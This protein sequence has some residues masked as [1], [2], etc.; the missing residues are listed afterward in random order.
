[1]ANNEDKYCFIQSIKNDFKRV[2]EYSQDNCHVSDDY[3]DTVLKVW[4]RNKSHLIDLMG[5]K[6]IVEL[7]GKRSFS[8]GDKAKKRKYND[9]LDYIILRAN[10]YELCKFVEEQGMDAFFGSSIGA[11]HLNPAEYNSQ[12]NECP[13]RNHHPTC[14][15]ISKCI[16][17]Q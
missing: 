8:L 10:N 16:Y 1:M 17:Q 2:I 9:F 13:S 7:P 5:G 6:L 14:S 12:H 11:K 3:V 4:A 15:E